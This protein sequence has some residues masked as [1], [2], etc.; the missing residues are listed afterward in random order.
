MPQPPFYYIPVASD[1]T[2]KQVVTNLRDAFAGSL[3]TLNGQEVS[4]QAIDAEIPLIMLVISGGTES[5]IAEC[6]AR[7]HPAY[8]HE[9]VILL[10]HPGSNSL[11]ASLEALALI[12]QKG[13]KGKIIFFK[14]SSDATA[15]SGLHDTVKSMFVN[16]RLR[17]SRVG[18]VGKPSEWLVASTFDDSVFA[19]T[20]GIQIMHY[21]LEQVFH[22]L[23][24]KAALNQENIEAVSG[25]AAGAPFIQAFQVFK[26][27]DHLAKN[28]KLDAVSVECFSLFTRYQT[29]GC[30]ALSRL[31]DSGV[32]AGCEGDLVSTLAMLWVKHLLGQ[33][34][35]MANP[36]EIDR[37][38]RTLWLAHCTVPTSM[39]TEFNEATH[40]ETGC[41]V[42]IAGK[43]ANGPVTL[44]RIGGTGLEK[45][46]V[47]DAEIIE[48]G[49]SPN[50]CRTQALIKFN[51]AD[52]LHELVHHPLGNHVILTSGKHAE[53]FHSWWKMFIAPE[54]MHNRTR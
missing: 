34:S 5:L 9:P 48:T 42:A 13:L 41:G 16:R 20:W 51:D 8:G 50:R 19:A 38:K 2:D 44:L 49:K 21:T 27:L 30:F 12:R 31:N 6:V 46:W 45:I 29:H 32:V 26:L 39:V 11:A 37:E 53:K 36:V 18:L 17:Q 47:A 1:I 3:A 7:R 10:A 25:F 52:A 14:T 40:F 43:L 23:A 35:W 33:N 28:E 54:Q 22:S 24:D 15:M 4:F